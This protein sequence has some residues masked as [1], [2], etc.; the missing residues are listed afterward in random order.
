MRET[1]TAGEPRE[2]SFNDP[3]LR[4]HRETLGCVGPLDDA[5]R[6]G[7]T[8][9]CRGGG[10]W[11]LVATIGKDGRDEREQCARL[12]VEHQDSAVAVL[13]VGRVHDDVQQ[14]AERVNEDVVFDAFNL[15]ARIV[16]DRV[17]A[18]TPFSADL[19]DLL[20]R[21]AALGLAS[22]PAWLRQAT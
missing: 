13:D 2:R 15:L 16:A 6:P 5:Q 18:L 7:A 10:T 22:L 20:S 9:A 17:D 14:Q 8:P 21:M 19:T 4:E 11:P 1:T 12:P 3:A